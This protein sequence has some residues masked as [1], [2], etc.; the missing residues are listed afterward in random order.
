M[1]RRSKISRVNKWDLLG[2]TALLLF[3]VTS[4]SCGSTVIHDQGNREPP[5]DHHGYGKLLL[6]LRDHGSTNTPAWVLAVNTDGSGV[7]RNDRRGEV[8]GN[9]TFKAGTFDVRA[10]EAMLKKLDIY[11]LPHC[12]PTES[13][14]PVEVNMGSVS[15][16]SSA[17]LDYRGRRMST[18]C[19]NSRLEVMISDQLAK[20]VAK[21]QP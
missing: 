13:I 18:F 6:T 1:A 7:L 8:N 11:H 15:F 10:L 21:A 2:V 12:S 9:R 20:V 3:S 16:G 19:L 4:A 14:A 5:V 17:S